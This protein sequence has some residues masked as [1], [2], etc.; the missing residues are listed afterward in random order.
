VTAV[1]IGVPYAPPDPGFDPDWGRLKMTW[2]SWD[3]STVWELTKPEFGVFLR[4]EGLRGLGMPEV[5]HKRDTSPAVAG[6]YWREVQ[7]QPRDV[8]WPLHL[9]SDEGTADWIARDRAFWRSMHPE[10]EGR[11]VVRTRD[12]VERS[13]RLRFSDDG[14]WAP[15]ADPTYYGWANYGLRL[16]AD[17]PFWEGKAVSRT[18]DNAN[19]T[20]DFFAASPGVLFIK[21]GRTTANATIVNGGDVD[22]WPKWRYSGPADGA[23]ISVNGHLIE[24]PIPLLA[25]QWVDIDTDPREQTAIDHTGASRYEDLGEVDWRGFLPPGNQQLS[26]SLDEP[27]EGA[28]I[29]MEFT[30]LYLRAW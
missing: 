7:Y 17:Q 8:F 18:W 25:N 26:L 20:G 30:P 1:V 2:E 29:G 15:E 27:G 12:G 10:H 23:T 3:G 19:E 16:Q 6:A 24:I 9:F 28:S 22:T 13:L 5:S 14:S 21:S 11:W 4:R